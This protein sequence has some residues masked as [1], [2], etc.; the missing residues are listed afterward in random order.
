MN[1]CQELYLLTTCWGMLAITLNKHL[2][3]LDLTQN[4]VS[5][6]H[7]YIMISY[8]IYLFTTSASLSPSA[9]LVTISYFLYDS[10][11]IIFAAR[12]YAVFLIHHIIC[13]Y[14]GLYTF[15][16]IPNS[17]IVPYFFYIELSNIFLNAYTYTKY[18]DT[19]KQ[20]HS[21]LR[22]LMIL[23]YTPLRTIVLTKTSYNMLYM[24]YNCSLASEV[25]IKMTVVA[26][27]AMSLWFSR[28]LIKQFSKIRFDERSFPCLVYYFKFLLDF[29]LCLHV[30]PRIESNV[31]RFNLQL[32]TVLNLLCIVC[33]WLYNLNW[34]KGIY[35]RL[36]FLAI[37]LKIT[38]TGLCYSL[39]I[40]NCTSIT[41]TTRV[42]FIFLYAWILYTLIKNKQLDI[43]DHKTYYGCVY[44]V[45]FLCSIYNLISYIATHEIMCI[46]F[47]VGAGYVW[48]KRISYP[49][50]FFNSTGWMHVG[51]TLGD[52]AYYFALT[53]KA[54][55]QAI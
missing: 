44:A 39:V 21:Q 6:L 4:L 38:T 30:I 42:H 19:Y 31:L 52:I 47:Y 50:E 36:D 12:Q 46:I 17:A 29:A 28:N 49:N 41:N 35:E 7:T 9:S 24:R 26:L 5:S 55:G 53:N 14:I 54:L 2:R 45:N 16:I 3:D 23:S 1:Y 32:F 20:L 8:C 13:I 40:S 11:F 34:Y 27:Y 37:N 22:P 33:S 43:H 25:A 48:Y 18:N 10:L 15:N 51:V